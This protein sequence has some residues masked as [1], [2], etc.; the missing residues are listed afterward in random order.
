MQLSENKTDARQKASEATQ[1][2]LLKAGTELFAEFG[3]DGATVDHIARKAKANKAMINYHF[4]GKQGLY[5]AILAATFA[6]SRERFDSLRESTQPADARLAGFVE[7]FVEMATRRPA[8]PAMVLREALSG[9]R[10]IS[11]RTL[12]YFISIF[13]L[14]REIVEQGMREGVFR[15]VD[16]FCTH[17]GLI[18]SLVFF[19][20]TAGFRDRLVAEGR[21]PLKPP[22]PQAYVGHILELMKRGLAAE[23]GL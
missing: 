18:G 4:G 8:F 20:S 9:G 14:V 12:P 13:A 21:L 1:E 17:L 6:P 5:E 7:I 23:G 22:D 15:P 3:F 16:P 19:F 2:A 10:H 11:G